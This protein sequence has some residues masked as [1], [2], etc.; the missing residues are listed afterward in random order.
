[1]TAAGAGWYAADSL[2]HRRESG[3]GYD[4]RGE[5]L[6]V[7]DDGFLRAAE[8]LT[9]APSPGATTSSC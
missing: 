2:R 6:E 7:G 8:A 3:H 1:M 5:P 4:L 9:G